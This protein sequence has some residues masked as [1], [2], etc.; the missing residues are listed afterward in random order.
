VLVGPTRLLIA[1][2]VATLHVVCQKL[3]KNESKSESSPICHELP[4]EG[5]RKKLKIAQ[6]WHLKW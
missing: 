2:V 4:A 1:C 3:D 5:E 6:K